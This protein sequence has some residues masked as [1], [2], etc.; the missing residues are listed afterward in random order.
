MKC[1]QE[2]YYTRQGGVAAAVMSALF[3]I[4][5]FS[6]HTYVAIREV[7]D[8]AAKGWHSAP[9]GR[10]T[11]D[12]FNFNMEL[13]ILE[14]RLRELRGHVDNFVLV[15]A[16]WT[17]TGHSK[18]LHFKAAK[19]RFAEFPIT[20]V[21]LPELVLP[22]HLSP[23]TEA[24]NVNIRTILRNGLHEGLERA[25][26]RP[27][28][29]VIISDLDEVPRRD[30]I[31][32]LN[33]C[34]G[35]VTPAEIESV[36]YIYDF[37][38]KEEHGAS[39]V[40][41]TTRVLPFGQYDAKCDG[42]WDGKWC[43]NELRKSDE[44]KYIHYQAAAGFPKTLVIP[45]GGVHMSYFLSTE[46]IMTK[47]ASNAEAWKRDKPSFNNRDHIECLISK[48]LH[49]NLRDHGTRHA[50]EDPLVPIGADFEAYN[51]SNPAIRQFY[52]RTIDWGA[53]ERELHNAES[54]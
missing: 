40:W 20:H 54:N 6:R 33:R 30:V 32:Q 46:L 4:S 8:C 34:D 15:E 9:E 23:G 42:T 26:A 7:E 19:E 12:A 10:R 53:C 44:F 13:D 36:P 27:D 51:A 28:D 50:G 48:C 24:Y 14:T 43:M 25:G 17:Q 47:I 2:H 35:Y 31:A 37:G 11:F 22:P 18:P 1:P 41:R 29:L 45:N 49:P 38:C 21:V 3:I 52:R 39:D 5:R 16:P